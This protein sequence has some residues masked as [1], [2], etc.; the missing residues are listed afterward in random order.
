MVAIRQKLLGWYDE[1]ARDLPWRR[2]RDPYAI[3]VSEDHASTDACRDGHPIL[4]ALPGQLSDSERPGG[5]GRRRRALALERPRLLPTCPPTP[6]RRP[7]SRRA[8]RRTSP[9]GCRSAARSA[10]CGSLHR[11]R[12]RQH[13]IREGRAH[14]RWK[15][16]ARSRAAVSNRHTGR[17]VRDQQARLGRGRTL[18]SRR[19]TRRVQSGLDGARRD[20]LHAQ[21]TELRVLPGCRRLSGSRT[22]RGRHAPGAASAKSAEPDEARRSGGDAGSRAGAACLA[23][24]KRAESVCGALGLAHDAEKRVRFER[25]ARSASG[26]RDLRKPG[27]EIDWT[28]G[29]SCCR[30]VECRSTCFAPRGPKRNPPKLDGFFSSMS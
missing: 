3:W 8:V 17:R 4:R 28:T 22:R 9:R 16:D 1:A 19:P 18:G 23:P 10:R 12:H 13:C 6:C 14:R 27:P 11:G 7:G 26:R 5:S 15:C 24:S 25:C 21:A 30:T 20:G 2:T 29:P